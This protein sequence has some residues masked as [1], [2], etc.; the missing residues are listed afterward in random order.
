MKV[1]Y[2]FLFAFFAIGIGVYPAAYLF[3]D[4]SMGLL[5][6]KEDA[7][8]TNPIWNMTFY[9]HIYFGGLA[10]LTG[11][12]QFSKKLRQKRLA[13][14]RA[15]G[16]SYIASILISGT[17][18]LYVA[19]YATGGFAAAWGFATLSVAWLFTTCV[20]Y[21]CLRRKNIRLHQ[22]WMIRSYALTFAAVTLRI[23]LPLMQVAMGMEF[24]E[25]YRIVAWLCWIPNL[26]AAE[27]LIVRI[28]RRR[29]VPVKA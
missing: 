15:L 3:F 12:S 20:S 14:H 11:W 17:T 22:F 25:A 26:L 21:A 29:R 10:L 27:F 16:F 2:W 5:S 1:F 24:V 7:L 23:W 13:I 28:G 4:M 19:F 8:L 6:Y 9:L 18:G